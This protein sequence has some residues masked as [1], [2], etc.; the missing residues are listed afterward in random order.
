MKAK[1]KTLLIAA[2]MLLLTLFL[3]SSTRAS[4]SNLPDGVQLFT[5]PSGQTCLIVNGEFEGCYCS[6]DNQVECSA[7]STGI[8]RDPTSTPSP[9]PTKNPASTPT[10]K[11]KQEK[12]PNKGEG[13]GEEG[14]DPGNHPELGNDDED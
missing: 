7:G 3:W 9:E 12:N 2:I 10:E 11:E 5:I 8:P 6:C 4:E 14:A 13:N 1:I